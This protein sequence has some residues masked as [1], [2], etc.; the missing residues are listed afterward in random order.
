MPTAPG[1]DQIA[2]GMG[3]LMSI[4]GLPGQGPVRVGIPVADLAR[5]IF[6]GHGH[7]GRAAGARESRARASGC[8]PRCCRRRS[9]CSIS[10]RRA[11]SSAKRGA[12]PGRQ[13]PSDLDPDR[14]VPDR[15][16][17]HQHRRRPASQIY[18]RFCEALGRAATCDRPAIL[19]RQGAASENRDALNAEIETRAGP[20]QRR[21]GRAA[22]R[23]RRAG[24][25]IY[26]MDEMFADPQ[27]KHL[28]MAAPG[29]RAQARRR[30]RSI[31][32]AVNMSRTPFEMRTRHARTGRAHRGGAEGGRATTRTPSPDTSSAA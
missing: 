17:L 9:P 14:R 24:G 13:R 25:P 12:G 4:T 28:S 30:S 7:P 6:C 20:R 31:G 22:Q 15:G 1:F 16:R 8:R 29:E 11:G 21:A 10:R 27:V 2:Q 5:G 19:D 32:Q 18:K 23:G 3:G 26:K